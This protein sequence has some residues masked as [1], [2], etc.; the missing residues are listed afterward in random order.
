[1]IIDLMVINISTV[2]LNKFFVLFL[3]ILVDPYN[4]QISTALLNKYFSW[5]N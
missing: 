1:M 3:P 5:N 4:L 2:V